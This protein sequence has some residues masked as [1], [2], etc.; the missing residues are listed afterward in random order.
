MPSIP[1]L[2]KQAAWSAYLQT[3]QIRFVP[4][5]QCSS[6]AGVRQKFERVYS[7]QQPVRRVERSERL[8]EHWNRALARE[9]KNRSKLTS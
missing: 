1:E 3:V 8:R 7:R 2:E 5:C 9:T 4:A 6:C